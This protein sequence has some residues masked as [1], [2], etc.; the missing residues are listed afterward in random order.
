MSLILDALNRAEHE[1]KNQNAVPDL[2]TLHSPQ[3][4]GVQPG[5]RPL[6]WWVIGVALVLGALIL[7]LVVLL[8]R[9]PE[10][11]SMSAPSPSAVVAQ[12]APAA[13]A[14]VA[15][16]N[17]SVEPASPPTVTAAPA[18]EPA[19]QVTTPKADVDKLYAA[20]DTE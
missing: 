4:F 3:E 18:I 12:P 13:A 14:T 20:N 1:R 7:A 6:V 16:P 19:R 17:L 2:H 5:R 8:R 9:E 15:A 10:S 11:I